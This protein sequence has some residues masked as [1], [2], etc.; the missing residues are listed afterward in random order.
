MLLPLPGA[1]GKLAPE[2]LEEAMGKPQHGPASP[3]R[4]ADSITQPTEC[5]TVYTAKVCRPAHSP[6]GPGC[7]PGDLSRPGSSQNAPVLPCWAGQEVRAIAEVAHAHGAVLH[8]D[9]ARFANAVLATGS[10]PADLSWRAGVDVLSLGATKG[11]TMAAEAVVFF[12]PQAGHSGSAPAC[13][14]PALEDFQRR[15]KRAGH[16]LSVR[17]RLISPHRERRARCKAVDNLWPAAA[18]LRYW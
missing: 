13:S 7:N 4:S 2:V 12:G 14:L 11:G 5:G 15:Q 8:V 16:V 18:L 6:G 17:L 1:H 3:A 10:P 9:G